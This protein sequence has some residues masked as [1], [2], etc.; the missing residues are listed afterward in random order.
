MT[1]ICVYIHI[2]I[3]IYIYIYIDIIYIY[4]YI[5][6][7]TQY[8]HRVQGCTISVVTFL[9][10]LLHVTFISCSVL[11]V[12]CKQETQQQT[13]VVLTSHLVILR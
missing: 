5:Y 4:I 9:R 12:T 13:T 7:H 8:K 10:R 3:Y 6:I 11:D 1:T 2:H